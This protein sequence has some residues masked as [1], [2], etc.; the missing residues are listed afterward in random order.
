MTVE[1]RLMTGAVVSGACT[2]PLLGLQLSAVQGLLSLQ[3][4]EVPAVHTPPLHWSL[5]VQALPSSQLPVRGVYAVV[6]LDGSQRRHGLPGA[7]VPPATHALS[8]RQKPGSSVWVHP[9][10][11]LQASDVHA[12]P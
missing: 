1:L 3:F 5:V 8:I 6:E 11:P 9:L 2:Q 4:R 12:R 7:T 10:E